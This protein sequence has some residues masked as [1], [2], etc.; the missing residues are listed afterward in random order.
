MTQVYQHFISPH[1]ISKITQMLTEFSSF[2]TLVTVM[3]SEKYCISPTIIA[4]ISLAYYGESSY[5]VTINTV[6]IQCRSSHAIDNVVVHINS[7]FR[8]NSIDLSVN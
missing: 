8:Y 6:S 3:V 2:N 5:F 1:L 7:L 4:M